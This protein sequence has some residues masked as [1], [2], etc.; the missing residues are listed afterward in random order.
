MTFAEFA[1]C[2]PQATRPY[3]VTHLPA[4]QGSYS[5][6]L[7]EDLFWA[8]AFSII[9]SYA[10]MFQCLRIL[11]IETVLV[12]AACNLQGKNPDHVSVTAKENG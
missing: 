8:A 9:A 1:E 6:D 10:Q 3:P 4:L 12:F 5:S 2:R 7:E 11:G